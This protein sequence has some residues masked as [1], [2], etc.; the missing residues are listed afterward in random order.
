MRDEMPV[1]AQ[2]ER[3]R[4]LDDDARALRLVAA[5]GAQRGTDGG[6]VEAARLVREG[7]AQVHLAA[8][9]ECG[10]GAAR[11]LERIAFALVAV[12]G[13]DVVHRAEPSRHDRVDESE[14]GGDVVL[15]RHAEPGERRRA[16]RGQGELRR[17]LRARRR[18]VLPAGEQGRQHQQRGPPGS[19]QRRHQLDRLKGHAV[20]DGS[21]LT[22]RHELRRRAT[23]TTPETPGRRDD[24]RSSRRKAARALDAREHPAARLGLLHDAP[25]SGTARGTR[26]VRHVGPPRDVAQRGLHGI[27]HPGDDAGHLPLPS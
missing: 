2:R 12:H 18:R 26:G 21:A 17:L 4:E 1:G 7:G 19:R 5:S 22:Q 24:R 27:A 9:G 16:R 20:L 8:G 23:R 6:L 13:P 11:R 3:R 25:R 10:E 15:Q 14:H